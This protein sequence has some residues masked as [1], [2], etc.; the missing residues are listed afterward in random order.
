MFQQ[1]LMSH[2]TLMSCC[3]ALRSAAI[4]LKIK[5][6]DETG[7]N[8]TEGQSMFWA[9]ALWMKGCGSPAHDQHRLLPAKERQRPFAL[10]R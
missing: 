8:G 2:N 9:A 4:K 6:V 3:L 7:A 10:Y 5:F 1:L